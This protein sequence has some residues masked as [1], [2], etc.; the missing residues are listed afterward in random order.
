VIGFLAE[1]EVASIR[2]RVAGSK[3]KLRELGRWGGGKPPYGYVVVPNE[4][5]KGHLLAVDPLVSTVVRRI[6]DAVL[7]DG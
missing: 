5:G 1:G 6:V 4:D 2:E 3:R 7:D